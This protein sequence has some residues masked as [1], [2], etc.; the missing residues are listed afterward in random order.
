MA[1][2]LGFDTGGTY[3]DAVIYDEDK[4]VL[5][6][7]KSLTTKADLS[8]GLGKALSQLP[9]DIV[10]EARLVSVSTTLATN[11]MVEAH[12]TPA[13]LIMIGQDERALGR[14]GL[15]ELVG[16][17]PVA[18]V[19]GGHSGCRLFLGAQPQP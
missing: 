8:I 13:A 1:I 18:F 17:G 12:A 19:T 4:G 15:G 10:N 3:T 2:L 14:A 11:A 9:I 6:S 7:A 16:D 5:G